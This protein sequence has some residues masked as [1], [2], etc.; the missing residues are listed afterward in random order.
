MFNAQDN[1]AKDGSYVIAEYFGGSHLYGL[2]TP[3]SDIDVR[4]VF[5]NTQPEFILGTRR[6]EELRKQNAAIKE[7]I[8]YKELSH[9]MA[10][11]KRANSEALEVLYAH[12]SAFSVL[13]DEFKKVRAKAAD[14]VDSEQLFNCLRG[15]MQGEYR[16]AI[17]ERKGQIGGKRYAKLQE[18]GFSPKNF[19][20]LFRLAYAGVIF[21]T[22]NRFPVNLKDEP[23]HGHLMKVKTQPE[24]FTKE[25]LTENY[26]DAE[27]K[28][29]YA[30]E[31]RVI[32]RKF[33]EDVANQ[34]LLDVYLPFLNAA[35]KV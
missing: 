27:K 35:K 9:I 33:S 34:L 31:N 24:L 7:D 17:G 3:E 11:L 20:Q 10:L 18:V 22:E 28:L 5:V 29:V 23:I 8:V 19:T 16:L 2:N 25:Q 32:D 30:F 12:D 21:F 13:S 6:F 15:Y 1:L 4:G 14:L 26:L